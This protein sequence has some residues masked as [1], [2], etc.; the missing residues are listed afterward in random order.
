MSVQVD[1]AEVALQAEEV[2]VV[3]EACLDVD[4]ASALRA[5]FRPA[6]SPCAAASS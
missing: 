5:A 2:V 6:S 3:V 1:S 4:V